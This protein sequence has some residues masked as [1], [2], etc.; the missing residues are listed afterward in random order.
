MGFSVPE[1]QHEGSVG[2][3]RALQINTGASNGA[4]SGTRRLPH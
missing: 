3:N 4:Q 1:G 2:W